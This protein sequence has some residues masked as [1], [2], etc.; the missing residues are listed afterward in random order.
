L[1]DYL[2]CSYRDDPE[3]GRE[4]AAYLRSRG[5]FDKMAIR[6]LESEIRL[7]DL[8]APHIVQVAGE[9]WGGAFWEIRK[10]IGKDAADRLLLNAW[11]EV[12]TGG[13]T[14][15][16][17]VHRVIGMAGAQK[18]AVLAAF[19]RRSLPSDGVG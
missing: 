2:P 14:E 17:F 1:A 3:L 9:V 12:P 19:T 6:N 8:D 11:A 13:D 10:L 7:I 4:V 18:Q 16:L 5:G 15:P